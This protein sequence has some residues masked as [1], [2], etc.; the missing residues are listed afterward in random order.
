MQ[1][2][3]PI[4]QKLKQK[5]PITTSQALVPPSG[6]SA[7]CQGDGAEL[8]VTTSSCLYFTVPWR[9]SDE[10][11]V[12]LLSCSMLWLTDKKLQWAIRE[13]FLQTVKDKT[14]LQRKRYQCLWIYPTSDFMTIT[15]AFSVHCTPLEVI[16]PCVR[17]ILTASTYFIP[18]EV[19]LKNEIADTT[20]GP[21]LE[22]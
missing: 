17:K 4:L 21:S 20:E 1:L 14:A 2:I 11:D 15:Q 5:P 7:G 10:L 13:N 16:I 6:N 22:Y 9:C 12:E 19:G 18:N 8:F 3:Q